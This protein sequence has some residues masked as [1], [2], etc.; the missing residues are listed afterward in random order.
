MLH[1]DLLDLDRVV[2]GIAPM[3]RRLVREGVTV[4]VAPGTALGAVRADPSQWSGSS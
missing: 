4:E 3:L 2:A 1:P